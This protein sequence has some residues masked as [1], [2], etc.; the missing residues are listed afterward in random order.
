MSAVF[1]QLPLEEDF[2]WGDLKFAKLQ[3]KFRAFN[4]KF[5]PVRNNDSIKETELYCVLL[6]SRI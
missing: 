5:L 1:G 6:A 2:M 3:E 4:Q